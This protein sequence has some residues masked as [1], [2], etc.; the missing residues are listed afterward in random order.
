MSVSC[1]PVVT[2]DKSGVVPERL[3][4]ESKTTLLRSARAAQGLVE[5]APQIVDVLDA[6]TQ[7]QE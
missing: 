6:D 4:S 7:S 1:V 5:I 3:S 2:S